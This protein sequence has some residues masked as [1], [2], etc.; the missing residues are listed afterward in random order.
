MTKSWY[1]LRAQ[2]AGRAELLLYDVIDPPGFGG[3]SARDLARD[4][5]ALGTVKEIVVR[6]NSPGGDVFEGQ[7]IYTLL[8]ANRA[9]KTVMV[10]G[11][12]ASIASLIAMAGDEIVM[13]E[14][15]MM[16][17]HDPS[18]F[19]VGSAADMAKMQE[20]LGKVKD[21]LLAVY[22]S[23]TGQPEA[24][25]AQ[26]MTDETWMTGTDALARGFADRVVDPAE[27]A[28]S[29]DAS[30][31]GRFRNVPESWRPRPVLAQA[32][33]ISG[34]T[35]R[36]ESAMAKETDGVTA[37]LPDLAAVR[38]EARKAEAARITALTALARRHDCPDALDAAIQDG[39]T[40]QHFAQTILSTKYANPQPIATGPQR[41]ES[42]V[43]ARPFA[44]FGEQLLAIMQ[45]AQRGKKPD[46]RL[47]DI[48]NAVQGA[49]ETVPADGGW[50]VQQDFAAELWKRAYSTGALTSR[51][52]RVPISTGANGLK[53]NAIDE[54]SRATGS[55]WGG[56][57]VYRVDEGAAGTKSKPKFA[58]MEWSLKKLMGLFYA[59]DELL[60]DAA[61]LESIAMQAFAEEMA[62]VMDDEIM[63]GDGASQMYGYTKAASLITVA[64]EAG[65]VAITVK[66]ENIIKM[67]A[68]MWAPARMNA[69]WFVNQDVEPQ[70]YQMSLAVG[71]GGAPVFLPAGGASAAPFATLMSRPVVPV[72]HC[73]TLGTVG[74]IQLVDLTQYLMIERGGLDVQSSI[75]V[76]FLTDQNVFRFIMRND[77]QPLWRKALTPFKGTNTLS[78]FVVLATRA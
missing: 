63:N 75:H 48:R 30:Q 2:E 66:Y 19:V 32:V 40:E 27:M 57:Q 29:F 13:P 6:I 28:A 1:T 65:Q 26:W 33:P 34:P 41:I 77:G 76:E 36:R 59:T 45:A 11:L 61:A 47:L 22:G 73:A 69:V 58:K 43:N 3:I 39:S 23:R 60:Q 37:V 53:I 35:Q 16:M 42:V 67:W 9:K 78:P 52:R 72:E 62:F 18:G 55:R 74:D 24:T 49:S 70:L 8:R 46:Q 56:V 38:E 50:L 44:R 20:A 4:L 10:D 17:I 54:T 68:R 31:L 71:T 14:N 25:I 5:K 51:V 12:A 7:A 15:A 64:K 21:T